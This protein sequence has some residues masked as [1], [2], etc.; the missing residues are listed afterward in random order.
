[1]LGKDL[2]KNLAHYIEVLKCTIHDSNKDVIKLKIC[3]LKNKMNGNV[4]Y[5]PYYVTVIKSL[6]GRE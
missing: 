2:S 6:G 1:M 3:Y 4:V 5:D